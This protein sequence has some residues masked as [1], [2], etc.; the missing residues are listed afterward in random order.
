M[1]KAEVQVDASVEGS[2]QICWRE[3]FSVRRVW[4]K[5]GQNPQVRK[6]TVRGG[7]AW[8]PGAGA[9]SGGRQTSRVRWPA[10]GMAQTF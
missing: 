6:R 3:K 5:A 10:G 8:S 7:Q 1:L 2:E 9:F 4:E